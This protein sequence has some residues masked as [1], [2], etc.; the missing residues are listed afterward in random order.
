MERDTLEQ[1]YHGD[2]ADTYDALRVG[3]TQWER[4]HEIVSG[5]LAGFPRGT[6]V[7]DV[8]VGT[9][10][11]LE[12]YR[13]SGFEAV[14]ADISSSMLAKAR[15][16][17][18]DLQFDVDLVERSVDAL[19][20]ED[21]S[22]DVVVCIRFL[23]WV[24]SDFLARALAELTRLTR[25]TIV[26]YIPTYTPLAE[27]RPWTIQGLVRGMRQLKL[28]FYR[29]RTRSDSVLHVRARV[30]AIADELGLRLDQRICIDDPSRRPWKLGTDRDIYVFTRG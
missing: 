23:D 12:L 25:R 14:G 19:E 16:K 15:E 13:D 29:A 4:E 18:T 24:D 28:R 20:F 27:L 6:R 30:L 1:K 17:A 8:P 11:F 9:G 5:V 3:T 21:E 7:L 2:M 22:F 10:R 26:A